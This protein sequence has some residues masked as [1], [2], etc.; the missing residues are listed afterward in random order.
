MQKVFCMP[1]PMNRRTWLTQCASLLAISSLSGC[2]TLLY[3]ERRGQ[4]G[5]RIDWKVVALDGIGLLIFFVPGVI[6]FAVDIMTGA[7][8]LPPHEYRGQNPKTS[9]EGFVRIPLPDGDVSQHTIAQSIYENTG[10]QVQLDEG[11]CL[12]SQLNT[13]REFEAEKE[14]LARSKQN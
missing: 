6:A 10:K 8:Y 13:L 14:R 7:I 9:E 4:P 2:G 11:H 3:P 1:A 12:T 5:G